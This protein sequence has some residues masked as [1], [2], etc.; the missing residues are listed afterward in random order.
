MKKIIA[1]II[2]SFFIIGM[3]Q[4]Q[5]NQ[6]TD[7]YTLQD[8]DVTVLNGVITACSTS[9]T[10]WGTGKLII[11]K[12][13]DG[14]TVSAISD[15]SDGVFQFKKINDI[16]FPETL[17]SIG[18]N[19]FLGNIIDD[20]IIPDHIKYLGTNAFY[21][22]FSIKTLIISQN[23]DTIREGTFDHAKINFLT[24]VIVASCLF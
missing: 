14:Q 15:G 21:F 4:A 17:S 16:Q 2:S 12:T 8:A 20:L 5:Y 22:S 19:A 24:N 1:S 18:D 7:T 6:A 3:A 9:A 11:P 23:I 10:E 13:L